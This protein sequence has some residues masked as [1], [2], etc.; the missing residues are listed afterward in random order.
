LGARTAAALTAA[1][2]TADA[3]RARA[4]QLEQRVRRLERDKELLAAEVRTMA[5]HEYPRKLAEAARQQR[6]ADERSLEDA[7]KASVALQ[8]A[9]D[10]AARY[11]AE[12]G[13]A[14]VHATQLEREVQAERSARRGDA[15]AARERQTRVEGELKAAHVRLAE[16][17]RRQAQDA[18]AADRMLR[19]AQAANDEMRGEVQRLEEE[20]EA[21]RA[22]LHGEIAGLQAEYAEIKRDLDARVQTADGVHARR[23]ADAQ[24]RVEQAAAE[25]LDARAQASELRGALVRAQRAAQDAHD[26]AQAD[27]AAAAD[28]YRALQVQLA[29]HQA[30]AERAAREASQHVHKL[31]AQWAVERSDLLA[32]L[33]AAH[34]DGF[35]L[36]D[37]L[38][39][40][41]RSA[42]QQAA[43]DAADVRRARA[44]LEDARRE[45]A[46][47]CRALEDAARERERQFVQDL[48]DARAAHAEE[49]A[50]LAERCEALA[51]HVAE[52]QDDARAAWQ[53]RDADVRARDERLAQLA[54][55]LDAL[56]QPADAVDAVKHWAGVVHVL[57]ERLRL[58]RVRW[59]EEREALTECVE[60]L[61]HREALYSV[62]LDH[63][64][65]LL[66]LKEDARMHM[67]REARA[68]YGELQEAAEAAADSLDAE[69]ELA[70][71][72]ERL[73]LEPTSPLSSADV[74]HE[75]AVVAAGVRRQYRAQ[76]SGAVLALC[77]SMRVCRDAEEAR[78]HHVH[79]Q[80]VETAE[81]AADHVRVRAEDACALRDAHI[82]SLA[83]QVE[84]LSEQLE[85][86]E[87]SAL[88]A[89]MAG[90]SDA[91][92]RQVERQRR[93]LE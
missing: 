67:V 6:A 29:E 91:L 18:G 15:E 31:E 50:A 92:A 89:D 47:A 75:V 51:M 38:D 69:A 71:D 42:A 16:L 80:L 45:H 77:E 27:L 30:A 37:A 40:L 90:Q 65:H 70:H 10:L 59:K 49:A 17:E 85:Q 72:L 20:R 34:K 66:A 2:Q 57:G 22:R 32:K 61:E 54:D 78:H 74:A 60:R 43:D 36:R 19:A 86:T 93:V 3:A 28:D 82:D 33:D 11:M 44:D 1:K 14:T 5:A 83:R 12:L 84:E 35:R 53:A 87:Q 46:D 41:Q 64:E 52:A 39:A 4:K 73:V 81:A 23:L 24:R 63:V 13:E 58:E 9:R 79:A 26:E 88:P 76:M 7:R 56:A 55:E 21:T 62:A 48:A 25:L 8:E 68:L